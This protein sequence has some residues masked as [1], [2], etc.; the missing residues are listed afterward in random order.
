MKLD[1]KLYCLKSNYRKHHNY[2]LHFTSGSGHLVG[3]SYHLPSKSY[4]IFQLPTST[5]ATHP[6]TFPSHH[7][8]IQPPFI[9]PP[10]NQPVLS[11]QIPFSE[12]PK[13]IEGN[14]VAGTE[15]DISEYDP[16]PFPIPQNEISEI[17]H[18][19]AIDDSSVNPRIPPPHQTGHDPYLLHLPP[20]MS[21]EILHGTKIF[22]EIEL[23]KVP[24]LG[25]TNTMAV[26]PPIE[27]TI[28]ESED[29]DLKFFDAVPELEKLSIK[30][31]T[32]H[33]AET[34]KNITR[35]RLRRRRRRKN[36]VVTTKL[37]TSSNRK[38]KSK[39]Q[40]KP[41]IKR[42]NS[43]F[44]NCKQP[45]NE[46]C[47]AFKSR[48]KKD[49]MLKVFGSCLIKRYPKTRKL[50]KL[51]PKM[52]KSGRGTIQFKSDEECTEFVHTFFS[53]CKKYITTCKDVR[54]GDRS[55]AKLV[56]G[57]LFSNYSR[58]LIPLMSVRNT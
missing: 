19:N 43:S 39:C 8:T 42:L 27:S 11:P 23:Q 54:E 53:K 2:F 3:F 24:S 13:V 49:L 56:L 7:S 5:I 31:G 29:V 38:R 21:P 45:L 12:A 22:P 14:A 36:S 41:E 50:S 33:N 58:L 18:H 32:D 15:T 9:Q 44:P 52:L 55:N 35:V 17:D 57:C 48:S 25:E 34:L 16:T 46:L 30:N 51:S 40:D 47:K 20:L 4:A 37:V 10:F 28:K 1:I 6:A 26:R